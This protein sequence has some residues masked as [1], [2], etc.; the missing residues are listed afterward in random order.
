MVVEPKAQEELAALGFIYTKTELNGKTVY[1]FADTE[2]LQKHLAEKY[3]DSKGIQSKKS[4][5]TMSASEK[6]EVK[7]YINDRYEYYDK[8]SGGYA[9]DKYTET[10]WKETADKFGISTTDV[11]MIWAEH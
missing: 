11:D 1:A 9:G 3:S 2:A 4:A 7:A 6:S 8:M 10:I 5:L